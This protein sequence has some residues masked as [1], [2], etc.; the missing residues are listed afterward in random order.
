MDQAKN[1]PNEI[2]ASSVEYLHVFGLTALAY[3]W[4]KMATVA[5]P[6]T[7]EEAFY[8]AKVGTARFFMKRLLPRYIGL[9]AAVKGGAEPLF[10]LDEEMFETA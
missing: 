7:G 3:M 1:N 5:L 9:S 10:E 2:G 8:K 4:A 6:K